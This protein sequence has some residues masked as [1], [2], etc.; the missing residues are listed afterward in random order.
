MDAQ[1]TEH[2]CEDDR[3][4]EPPESPAPDPEEDQDRPS[5]DDDPQAD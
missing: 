5:A 4:E 2:P 3:N 1:D